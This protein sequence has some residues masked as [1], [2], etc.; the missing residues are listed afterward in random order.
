MNCETVIN[1]ARVLN[2]YATADAKRRFT[3]ITSV[4]APPF[5]PAYLDS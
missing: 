2:E 1:T 3:M 4:T 5:K